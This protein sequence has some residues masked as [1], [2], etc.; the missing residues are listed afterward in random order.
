[1]GML[2]PGCLLADLAVVQP[3]RYLCGGDC[4]H[5]HSSSSNGRH[6]IAVKKGLAASAAIGDDRP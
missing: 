1:M 5:C 4:K 6:E 3:V 2:V